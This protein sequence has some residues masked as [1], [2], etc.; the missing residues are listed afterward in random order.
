MPSAVATQK[1]ASRLFLKSYDHDPG[2]TTAIVTS[3]DGGTTKIVLDLKDYRHFGV[4]AKPN[5]VGGSGITLLEIIASAASDMS[6]PVV[7]VAHAATVGDALADNIWLEC[8]D[9]EVA[10]L[11]NTYRYVAARLTMATATDEA[12]VTYV[13]VPKVEA[14]NLTATAIT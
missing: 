7:V 12:T 3:A 1:I 6:S 11:G 9:N 2:A 8:T 13:G 14:A 4:M 5:I 10:Q